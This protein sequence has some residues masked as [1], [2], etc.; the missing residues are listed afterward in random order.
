MSKSIN[1]VV[2]ESGVVTTTVTEVAPWRTDLLKF[3]AQAI[4]KH[5]IKLGLPQILF[6]ISPVYKVE[7]VVVDPIL[8]LTKV[9]VPVVDLV[10][11]GQQIKLAGHI[12]VGTVEAL[13]DTALVHHLPEF[14]ELD[15]SQYRG[16]VGQCDHCHKLRSRKSAVILQSL[17]GLL[18]VGKSCLVDFTGAGLSPEFLALYAGFHTNEF[19]GGSDEDMDWLFGGGKD[20]SPLSRLVSTCTI[21]RVYGFCSKKR[22]TETGLAP[23]TCFVDILHSGNTE[24]KSYK[25]L[26][27]DIKKAGGFT[28][29]DAAKAQEILE[30]VKATPA[31]NSDYM[32]NLKALCAAERIPTKRS[33][34]VVSAYGSYA[35]QQAR[36]SQPKVEADKPKG[37]IGTIGQRI[38][39]EAEVERVHYSEGQYGCTTILSL[40]DAQGHKLVWFAS[41]SK[42]FNKGDKL[43]GKATIKAHKQDA[44]WGDST[45]LTRCA[46]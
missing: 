32:W 24:S 26:V 41:G 23:T 9:Q 20:T 5:A 37:F 28:D 10:V 2:S 44:K 18:V 12:V 22:S 21:A 30:W 40:V 27:E 42:D 17:E 19:L 36:D 38:N 31:G 14:S 6:T 15:L 29:A 25:G 39:V 11:T 33:A 46:F 35:A 8:G 13:G 7:R 1:T 45:I 43:A 34:L 3:K 16:W 4:N